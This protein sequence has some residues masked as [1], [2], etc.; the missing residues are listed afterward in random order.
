MRIREGKRGRKRGKKRGEGSV[1]LRKETGTE[2]S[3]KTGK[4]MERREF[5]GRERKE[6]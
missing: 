5:C 6:G 3:R 2:G 1:G 4:E